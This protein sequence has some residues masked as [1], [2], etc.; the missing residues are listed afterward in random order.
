M[1]L[2][3]GAPYNTLSAGSIDDPNFERPL[4]LH[5]PGLEVYP[6]ML[7]AQR[8]DR[9]RSDVR[10]ANGR[11]LHV[12][13]SLIQRVPLPTLLFIVNLRRWDELCWRLRA[14]LGGGVFKKRYE[15]IRWQAVVDVCGEE[16]E[17]FRACRGKEGDEWRLYGG[18]KHIFW[19]IAVLGL[20]CPAR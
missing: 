2:E 19:R 15:G 16:T 9:R 13:H 3:R 12:Q 6:R 4:L 7:H 20:R 17:G 8:A 10:R 1:Y 18:R 14:R 5:V 11:R